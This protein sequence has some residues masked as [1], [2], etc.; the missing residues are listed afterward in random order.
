MLIVNSRTTELL[1]LEPFEEYFLRDDRPGRPMVWPLILDFRGHIDRKAFEQALADTL[2]YEPLLTSLAE[3][4]RGRYYWTP[5]PARTNV[6]WLDSA[7]PKPGTPSVRIAPV[8]LQREPGLRIV[9]CTG[10]DSVQIRCY[11]HHACTDGVGGIRFMFNVF[12]RYG[13]LL[14]DDEG[15]SPADPDPAAVAR[16]GELAIEL[17]EKISAATIIRSITVETYK[18]LAIRPRPLAALKRRPAEPQ[19]PITLRG[20]VSAELFDRLRIVAR[21]H[22]SSV[23]DLFLRDMFLTVCDWN[24]RTQK[25][26]DRDVIRILMPTNLRKAM[27]ASLPAANV[28]GYA[29]LSRRVSDC[30]DPDALLRHIS[31]ETKFIRAWSLGAMFLDGLKAMRRIPGA[32]RLLT[33]NRFCHST[34]VVSNLGPLHALAT[35]RRFRRAM[36]I[37]TGELELIG[38]YA[39]PPV[40][41]HTWASLAVI[42][43]QGKL[44][45]AMNIDLNQVAERQ[46]QEFFDLYHRRLQQTA[47]QAGSSASDIAVT[48][49]DSV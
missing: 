15:L 1:P 33:S 11:F 45:L 48:L 36:T 19:N 9:A 23:N 22:E 41:P 5:S 25:M 6:E 13:A 7:Q 12:A 31:G 38:A 17:P 34:C 49:V 39:A 8:C 29:F 16:R 42:G 3:R 40:R 30:R 27:H 14:G 26:R 46:G 10:D 47:A 20:E 32:V 35:Q 21:S 28:L 37:Q 43:V 24:S 18:W 4:K 44:C 2:V